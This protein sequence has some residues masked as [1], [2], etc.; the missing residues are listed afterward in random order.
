MNKRKIRQIVAGG[1]CAAL[2]ASAFG[3]APGDAQA[4]SVCEG[5]SICSSSTPP[6]ML[7]TASVGPNGPAPNFKT[8]YDAV[9]R[10]KEGG[11]ITVYPNAD[12][13][14]TVLDEPV[15]ITT[16]GDKI[17]DVTI[18]GAG[19]DGVRFSATEACFVVGSSAKLTLRNL[20]LL[21]EGSGLDSCLKVG[22]GGSLTLD[23]TKIGLGAFRAGHGVS[24]AA[25]ARLSAPAGQNDIQII[26][27]SSEM[28][29]AEARFAAIHAE[30][31]AVFDLKRGFKTGGFNYGVITKGPVSGLI[32]DAIISANAI[33]VE[34]GA[35]SG[36]G[37]NSAQSL[38]FVR[39]L[40][41]W[42]AFTPSSSLETELNGDEIFAEDL[43]ESG[44]PRAQGFV[45][46][47]ALSLSDGASVVLAGTK[48]LGEKIVVAP[49]SQALLSVTEFRR[50]ADRQ[51]AYVECGVALGESVSGRFLLENVLFKSAPVRTDLDHSSGAAIMVGQG[52]AGELEVFEATIRDFDIGAHLRGGTVDRSID[53]HDLDIRGSGQVGVLIGEGVLP[54][55]IEHIVIDNFDD[56][57]AVNYRRPIKAENANGDK[58]A[59]CNQSKDWIRNRI[60]VETY[61]DFGP[62]KVRGKICKR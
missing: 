41:A 20:V 8:L 42:S 16:A 19:A 4:Q 3:L 61:Q 58:H 33:G 46:G 45:P 48:I 6:P 55:A 53:L 21:A 35:C 38:N 43:E 56:E 32:A 26:R 57:E 44:C 54:N 52:F 14:D 7:S 62:G 5:Q 11:V 18:V 27:T 39:G 13:S 1:L 28:I 9:R 40:F 22:A 23:N 34:I 24:L 12:G 59:I 47:T 10:M 17:A 50:G 51:D 30:Q 49:E 15:S 31:G 37:C 29:S 60:R 25:G 36:A 2:M